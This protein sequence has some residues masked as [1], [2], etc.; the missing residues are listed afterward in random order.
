MRAWLTHR[1]VR[2]AKAGFTRDRHVYNVEEGSAG[3]RNFS[4]CLKLRPSRECHLNAR[5]Q[6]QRALPRMSG[7]SGD[8]Q[9]SPC[10]PSSL[11]ATGILVVGIPRFWA[12]AVALFKDL[13]DPR[14]QSAVKPPSAPP[15]PSPTVRMAVISP[16]LS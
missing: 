11:Q 12:G 15:M 8:S 1:C 14:S 6:S 9:R 4:F 3:L 2:D 13:R 16:H 10:H 7:R 5:P